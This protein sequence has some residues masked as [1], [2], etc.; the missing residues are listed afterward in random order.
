MIKSHAFHHLHLL[1]LLTFNFILFSLNLPLTFKPLTSLFKEV[2]KDAV[3][4]QE[5]IQVKH[6]N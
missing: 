5:I 2:N 1:P 3:F 4:Y 6:K